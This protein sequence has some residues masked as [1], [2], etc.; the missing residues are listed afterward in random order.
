LREALAMRR[1]LLCALVVFPAL[2]LAA[3]PPDAPKDDKK[4][5]PAKD[6]KVPP[7]TPGADLPGALRPFVVTG[8]FIAKLQQQAQNKEKVE[9]RFH[10]P[11]AAHGLDPMVLLIVKDL[12]FSDPFKELL[13]RLDNAVEKNP[14]VRLAVTVIFLSDDVTFDP[15]T[16]DDKREALAEQLRG[17]AAALKLRHVALALDGPTDVERYDVEKEAAFQVILARRY[18]VVAYEAIPRDRLTAEKVDQ[19]LA[20]LSDKFKASRK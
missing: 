5:P 8:P 4:A 11:L 17:L 15:T 1:C 9:G 19:L 6:K 7:L 12:R 10:C 14:T 13:T 16:E 18:K 2:V 20:L 3:D